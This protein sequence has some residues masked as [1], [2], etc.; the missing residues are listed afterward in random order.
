MSYTRILVALN[1]D[2][3]KP[4]VF[5][6]ALDLAKKESASLMV[7]HCVRAANV[8]GGTTLITDPL[9][10]TAFPS[11][12]EVELQQPQL[13]QQIVQQ[14]TEQSYQWLETYRRKLS[15]LSA[16]TDV[17][18]PQRRQANSSSLPSDRCRR[19]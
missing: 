16:L 9:L 8:L 7:F 2:Q 6:Q 5:E 4:E 17:N 11:G 1:Q 3:T 18:G 19:S 15:R 12:A 14:Q 13:Q 10:G